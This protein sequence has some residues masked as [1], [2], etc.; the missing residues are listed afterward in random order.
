MLHAL[1][2]GGIVGSSLGLTGGGGSILAVPLLIYGLGFE[3]R[4]AVALSLGIVGAT[5][6]YGAVLHRK[7]KL[8][9]WKHGVVLG[10]GGILGVPC[11]IAL[12]AKISA[13][14]SLI[15]FAVLM[16]YIALGMLFPS[17]G[18]TA[19]KWSRCS[20]DTQAERVHLPCL[21]KLLI[22]GVMTGILSGLFGVGG[23]FLLIPALMSVA[24]V[25]VQHAMATSLVAIVI[26]STSGLASNL[27]AL[28]S[29]SATISALFLTG[30]ALGMTIGVLT[31]RLFSPRAL[32]LVFGLG[33]LATAVFVLIRNT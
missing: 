1:L 9:R 25:G 10:I 16:L 19:P 32:Q 7:Q 13:Q 31:K 17:Y 26:I 14:L 4:Q 5:S 12:G 23:G 11:G 33:V 15:F 21:G 6:L 2:Y 24:R 28:A 30:S 8:V 20:V 18:P 22:A 29:V 3:F 27:S